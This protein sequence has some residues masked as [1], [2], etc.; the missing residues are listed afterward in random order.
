MWVENKIIRSLFIV[1]EKIVKPH[2]NMNISSFIFF[3][4]FISQTREIRR[5]T[6]IVDLGKYSENQ[7]FI[8]KIE[9]FANIPW[10][11]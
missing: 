1:L 4:Y 9:N 8:F 11:S 5:F 3:E 2:E 7:Y 10:D 6:Q